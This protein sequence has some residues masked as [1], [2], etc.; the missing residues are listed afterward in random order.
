MSIAYGA[1]HPEETQMD[2]RVQRIVAIGKKFGF[3]LDRTP[4]ISQHPDGGDRGTIVMPDGA[5]LYVS[6][7]EG[8]AEIVHKTKSPAAK[9][10]TIGMPVRVR[11]DQPYRDALRKR[12]TAAHVVYGLGQQLLGE[13]F[14]AVSRT[15][16][17]ETYS[18]WRGMAN[19][20]D[21]GFIADLTERANG[22]IGEGRTVSWQ[23]KDRAEAMGEIAPLYEQ[24]LPASASRIRL[25]RIDG[26]P[27]DPCS[28]VHL[29]D[30]APIGALSIDRVERRG[31]DVRLVLRVNGDTTTTET[32]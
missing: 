16:L 18:E 22:L 32:T 1:D 13:A 28:G 12:H 9:A 4:F 7:A 23:T 20:I 30:T 5:E 10:V 8:A 25:V 24:I 29:R 26:L 2:A 3:V 21:D 17:Q 11:V 27:V 31:D 14:P 19:R 15:S 6:A